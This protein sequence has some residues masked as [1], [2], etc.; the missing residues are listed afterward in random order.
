MKINKFLIPILA[1]IAAFCVAACG[2]DPN[3]GEEKDDAQVAAGTYIVSVDTTKVAVEADNIGVCLYALDGTLVKEK[4]LSKGKAEF[5]VESDSYVATLSGVAENLSFSSVML[6]ESNRK[7]TVVLNDSEYDEYSQTN[8]F[9]FTLILISEDWQIDELSVQIC[10]DES[11]RPFDFTD[12]NVADVPLGCGEYDIKVSVGTVEL[13]NESYT[14][15]A[16]NRFYV[17]QV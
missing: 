17:I 9:T 10:N 7:A 16:D 12:G 5:E 1:A 14:V 11:C 2:A 13:F 3:K 4:K 8:I 15:T 6:T